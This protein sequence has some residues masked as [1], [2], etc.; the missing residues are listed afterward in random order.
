MAS[1]LDGKKCRSRQPVV[2]VTW[3]HLVVGQKVGDVYSRLVFLSTL[4]WLRSCSWSTKRIQD[5]C[6]IIS[7]ISHELFCIALNWFLVPCWLTKRSKTPGSRGPQ[8]HLAAL[9]LQSQRSSLRIPEDVSNLSKKGCWL[10]KASVHIVSVGKW[11]Q[12]D[13]LSKLLLSFMLLSAWVLLELCSCW[14][15]TSD[16]E[17][18]RDDGYPN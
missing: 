10:K 1:H 18:F 4:C 13:S 2:A 15:G 12:F 5:D 16:F 17:I 7:R 6:C 9:R 8:P 14:I 3:F 11:L